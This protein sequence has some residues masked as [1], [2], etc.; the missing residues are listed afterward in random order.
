MSAEVR[1][2]ERVGKRRGNPRMKE[3]KRMELPR[4]YMAKLLYE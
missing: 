4:K 2:Q 1:R 3:G